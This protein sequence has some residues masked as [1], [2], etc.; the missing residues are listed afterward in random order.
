MEREVSE[1]IVMANNK[2]NIYR[3]FY[4]TASLLYI[5]MDTNQVYRGQTT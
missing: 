4:G 5:A 2:H 3:N 1:Y